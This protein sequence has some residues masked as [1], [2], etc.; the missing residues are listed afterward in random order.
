MKLDE[1]V[2][3]LLDVLP[4]HQPPWQL[5]DLHGK[6]GVVQQLQRPAGGLLSGAVVVVAQHQLLGVAAQQPQLLLSQRRTHGSHGIVKARL[7]QRHHVQIALTEDDIGPLGLLSQIHAVQNTALAV[8]KCFRGV[9]ILGLGLVQ[10]TAAEA[11][12]ITPHIND[13][14]HQPVAE[15]I[16][17]PPVLPV[18]RQTGGDQLL[19]GVALVGHRRQQ[20]IPAVRSRPHTE[21][22]GNAPADAALVQIR[23]H[24]RPLLGLEDAVIVPGGIPVQRQHPAAKLF[25]SVAALLRYREVGPLGQKSDGIR[26]GQSLHLHDEVHDAAAL[27]AAEAVVKLLVRQHMEGGSLFVVEGTAAPVAAA[28][29]RQRD[30]AAYNIHNVAAGQQLV[31][32]IL[33]KRHP[34]PSSPLN[35]PPARCAGGSCV[36]RPRPSEKR[37]LISYTHSG[38]DFLFFCGNF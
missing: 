19:L 33:G 32:K 28:L 13:R 11:H 9:H 7:M 36:L 3:I 1:V 8:C 5:Q 2:G 38:G 25:R 30:V 29:G 24:R 20:G 12:H 34:A 10:H 18:H 21:P 27:L 37:L 4:V 26:I 35:F 23:L 15:L 14:Q 22:H 16:I 31:Q 17:Q 6:L